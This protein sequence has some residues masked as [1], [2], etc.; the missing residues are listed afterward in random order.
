MPILRV[1]LENTR[2]LSY[3]R[4]NDAWIVFMIDNPCMKI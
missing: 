4:P 3:P 1:R 2:Y